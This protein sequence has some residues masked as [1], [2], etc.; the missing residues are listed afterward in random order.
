MPYLQDL[1]E[2]LAGKR[3]ELAVSEGPYAREFSGDQ[4]PTDL[5][6]ALQLVKH[7]C[8]VL[9]FSQGWCVITTQLTP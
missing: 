4:S 9:F 2:V 5:E 8:A 6:T 3:A 7:Q 1:P